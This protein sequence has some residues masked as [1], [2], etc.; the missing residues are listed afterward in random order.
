MLLTRS[1]LN[2]AIASVLGRMFAWDSHRKKERKIEA[3]TGHNNWLE[4]FKSV[5]PE[6]VARVLR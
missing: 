5:A 4:P 6:S 1:P 3:Q 2:L